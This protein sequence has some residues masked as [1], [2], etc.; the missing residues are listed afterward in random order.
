MESINSDIN[1]IHQVLCETLGYQVPM[2]ERMW[3]EALKMGMTSDCVKLVIKARRERIKAGVRHEECLLLRNI[4]GN[5]DAIADVIEEAAAIR[6]KM[7]V[8]VFSTGKAQALRDTGRADAPEQG[9]MRHISE[10]MQEMRKAA[11]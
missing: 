9:P 2:R 10:V 1:E 8:K 3:F 7:R 4:I 11:Q 5:E 6:A